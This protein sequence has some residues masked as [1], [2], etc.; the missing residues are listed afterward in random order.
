MKI[1][2]SIL[3][4]TLAISANAGQ[5]V[6][7]TTPSVSIQGG[8]SANAVWHAP[9]NRNYKVSVFVPGN[10]TT[11]NVLYR[12]YPKGKDPSKTECVTMDAYYPCIEIAVNQALNKNKWVQLIVNNNSNTTW[13][14]IGRKGYVT[15]ASNNL[16]TT[17]SLGVAGVRFEEVS[18][19]V[20]NWAKAISFVSALKLA[21]SECLNDNSGVYTKCDSIP[22]LSIY[23]ITALPDVDGTTGSS[24]V[25]LIAA[26]AAIQI[27]G[28]SQLA[29]CT[30]QFQPSVNLGA[31]TI[32]WQA[33]ATAA[34]APSKSVAECA[35][36]VKGATY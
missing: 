24:V 10:A 17:E 11:T 33:K 23:G 20:F 9:L 22:E 15:V 13:D 26:T 6:P 4:I 25:T 36:Y 28:D 5:A 29:G 19:Y 14:F 1:K 30:F 34:V 27:A 16:S 3:A 21:I 31:G 18:P 7:I 35:Q 8:S 32:Y 12:F 2:Q